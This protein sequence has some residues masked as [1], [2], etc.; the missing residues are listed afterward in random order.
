[1][2]KTPPVGLSGSLSVSGPDYLRLI[3]FIGKN[4]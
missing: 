2:D 1:M 4:L 3:H